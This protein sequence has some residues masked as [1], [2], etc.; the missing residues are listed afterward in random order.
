M[1]DHLAR[2]CSLMPRKLIIVV[3]IAI[4]V[5]LLASSGGAT[6]L[7][8]YLD[9][10]T[11]KKVDI[12]FIFDTSNSMGGEINDLRAVANKF[13]TDL[14]AYHIDYQ[15][16]LVEFRDFPIT[17][18]EGKKIQCG[19]PGDF[20]YRIK[21]NGTLTSEIS[22]FSSWLEELEAGGGGSGGPEAVLVAL[23]HAGSDL[24]W[25]VDAEKEI[26][27][28]TDA[29]PHLDGSCCNAEG[30]TLDGTI[31]GITHL[32]ARVNVI[33]PDDPSLKKIAKDTG[34][35]FFKIR[36]D[37]SLKPLL[38]KITEA[39]SY[40]FNATV[41]TTCENK[42]LVAKVQLVGKGI[43]PYLA[44]HTEVWMYLDQEG[45]RSRYNLSYDQVEMGY[46]V[47][48]PNVCGPMDLTVYG[49]VGEKSTVQ[50]L[51]VDCESCGDAA[52]VPG[53]TTSPNNPPV[54]ADLISDKTSP[55]DEGAVIT[56]TGEAF[57]PDGDLV[58]YKFF[59]DNEPVTDWMEE[60]TWT[61]TANE[62]G[63]HRI[64][65]RV[66][67]TK[68]AGPSGL[69]DR[70][71]ESFTITE[72][73]PTAPE[74]Q[75]P[76]IND[77]AAV[78][79][80]GTGI[81]WTANASDPDSYPIYAKY[82][83]N[84]MPMTDW[85]ASNNWTLNAADANVGGNL[86]EVQVRDGEHAGV[87]SYDDTKSVQ[88][89]LSSMKLMIQTWEKTFDGPNYADA[90]SVHQTN[91]GGYIVV[92]YIRS[93]IPENDIW[94]IKVD[95]NGNKLWDKTFGGP[96][97]DKGYS[98]QQTG[99]GGYIVVG[100]TESYGSGDEDVWLIKTDA[101]GNKLWDKTFG[102]SDEDDGKSVQLTSDG[103]YVIV[104]KV[105]YNPDEHKGAK[106]WLIKTDSQGNN[107]W[108]KSFDEYINSWGESVQQ[109]NDGGFIITGVAQIS[110]AGDTDVWLIKT[111][112]MGNEEWDRIFGDASLDSDDWGTSVQQTADAGY[113][114]LGHKLFSTD[115]S[116][117]LIKTDAIGNK[118]WDKTFNGG[119]LLPGSV[120]Q[121]SDGGYITV[122]NQLIKTDLEGNEEWYRT[123]DGLN[124][125]GHSVEQ[126]NDGGY[127]TAG[128]I[129]DDVWLMKTDANGNV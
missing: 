40:N 39:M 69:D 105:G 75:P 4:L 68:H 111:D 23:R 41:E 51:G 73:K 38:E 78:Q 63:S 52:E 106:V 17:C 100:V 84:G 54:I 14:E 99:D 12:V 32:G 61:W 10:L 66:R 42:N 121:T 50:V 58:Q 26:I 72:L 43:V 91:D 55:Q 129:H 29:G 71:I 5:L 46:L 1:T 108:D 76:M 36:S 27:L 82:L 107:L 49:R 102:G 53:S 2:W 22:T 83:L 110:R 57:D 90:N 31:F 24:Y 37:L 123:F 35:Q 20:A 77:L 94:L 33:G 85:I 89:N 112:S 86:V 128:S 101:N 104:G 7:D 81:I 62:T 6:D 25:R 114:V 13:A 21:G 16:G 60:K 93:E 98:V 87:D 19:S 56:W 79:G 64:E 124:N 118:V 126:T 96:E 70:K 92:G 113:I 97:N 34:G 3:F 15:L 127:I 45:N 30:D 9:H 125:W 67:D 122:G 74:N 65:V 117:W 115:G 11:D 44:G 120:K 47:E 103:G 88:F 95:A 116:E 119:M 109:T 59:L 28:L 80:E 18:G 48:V 8:K